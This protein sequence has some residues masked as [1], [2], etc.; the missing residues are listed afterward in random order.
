MVCLGGMTGARENGMP[1]SDGRPVDLTLSA[2]LGASDINMYAASVL[3][4]LF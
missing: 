3:K 1:V 4:W 2:F